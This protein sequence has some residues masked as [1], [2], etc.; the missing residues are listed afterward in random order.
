[1]RIND[2]YLIYLFLCLAG[3]IESAFTQSSKKHEIGFSFAY[4]Y[5]E[6]RDLLVSPLIYAGGE[7]PLRLSYHYKGTKN[8]HHL[9]ISYSSGSLQS[10]VGNVTDD[11][12]GG[13][14]YVYHRHVATLPNNNI[15]IFSGFI[16][17]NTISAREYKFQNLAGSETS[18]E[19][20][21]SL[22]LSLLSEYEINQKTHLGLQIFI[23]V[24]A[25]LLRPGFALGPPDGF[26]G[27]IGDNNITSIFTAGDVATVN[28]YLH[29]RTIV[30]YEK[31]VSSQVDLRLEYQFIFYQIKKPRKISTV[32]NS[33]AF[34]IILLF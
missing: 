10:S 23:P 28:N 27:D 13:L 25:Y 9:R 15:R 4:A 14:Q 31:N 18:G 2:H 6:N 22:N 17:D 34:G 12:R 8:R 19:F 16:W 26:N 5:H 24:L 7:A 3:T 21:S 33:L 1:M 29:M 11:I 30:S 20:L 32:S